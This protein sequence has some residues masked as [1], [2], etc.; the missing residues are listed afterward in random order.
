MCFFIIWLISFDFQ[1]NN[2]DIA[3]K[4]EGHFSKRRT[5]NLEIFKSLSWFFLVGVIFFFLLLRSS[6]FS[7]FLGISFHLHLSQLLAL[8][9]YEALPVFRLKF[10]G[11]FIVCS[12]LTWQ[13][14]KFSSFLRSS[15]LSFAPPSVLPTLV[16]S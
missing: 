8:H 15:F 11:Q 9:Y 10:M 1:E 4:M 2:K 5:G 6:F 14:L 7:I 12:T 13:I 16:I 3:I